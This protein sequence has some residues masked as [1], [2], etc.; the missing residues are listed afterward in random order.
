MMETEF[1]ESFA[2]AQTLKAHA[3]KGGRT[4]TQ[5][6]LVAVSQRIVTSVIASPRARAMAGYVGAIRTPWR[7][8]DEALVGSLVTGIVDPGTTIRI[9]RS[10]GPSLV[11]PRRRRGRHSASPSDS[12]RRSARGVF[13]MVREDSASYGPG[14]VLL[15]QSSTACWSTR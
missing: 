1:R 4:L 6:A 12:D 3:E 11:D 8:E 9:I 15:I 13:A 7:A 2:I 5:F 14:G 10:G